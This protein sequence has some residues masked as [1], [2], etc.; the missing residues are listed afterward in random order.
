MERLAV[1]QGASSRSAPANEWPPE[2]LQRVKALEE[3]LSATRKVQ[4]L[5]H[6]PSVLH[7]ALQYSALG[8]TVQ[9][10]GQCGTVHR[11]VQYRACALFCPKL[12]FKGD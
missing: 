10:I 8:S 7:W 4:Y 11:A 1:S 12:S 3:E 2:A 5:L 9:H 6:L